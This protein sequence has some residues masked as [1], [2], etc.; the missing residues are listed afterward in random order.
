ML[1]TEGT[2]NRLLFTL[3]NASAGVFRQYQI[4]FWGQLVLGLL[5]SLGYF[6][7]PIAGIIL[8]FVMPVIWIV[9]TY[10]YVLVRSRQNIKLPF[11]P[12][13]AKNPGNT[14]VIIFDVF[15]LAL[16]WAIILGG[17]YDPVWLKIVFTVVFPILTL[18]MLRNLVIYPFDKHR[19]KSDGEDQ[20]SE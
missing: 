16:I 4:T 14:L 2:S 15:F 13:M 18:S 9:L 7:S 12:W 11:P 1:P 8:G 3:I 10:R 19:D 6:D 5:Y 17:W 20:K